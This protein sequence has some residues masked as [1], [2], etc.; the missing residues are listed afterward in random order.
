M[1][2]VTRLN[3]ESL[4][5]N[6]D[7]IQRV[8]STPDTVVTLVD[9]SKLVVSESLDVVIDRVRLF[10]ASVMVAAEDLRS[11]PT[12]G[13]ETRELRLLSSSD[14]RDERGG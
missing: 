14:E 11:R 2:L 7:L 1:I 8:E 6:A 10:R 5:V 4:A 13:G 12:P 3:G 9:G